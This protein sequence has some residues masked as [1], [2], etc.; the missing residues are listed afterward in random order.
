MHV[1]LLLHFSQLPIAHSQPLTSLLLFL[2]IV[3]IEIPP[4]FFFVVIATMILSAFVVTILVD[5][6][7]LLQKVNNS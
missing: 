4:N 2:C 1:E 5:M 7:G 6:H 3:I